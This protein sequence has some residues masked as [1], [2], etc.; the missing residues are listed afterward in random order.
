M[1]A[2]RGPKGTHKIGESAQGLRVRDSASIRAEQQVRALRKETGEFFES[3]ILRTF[4]SKRAAR[5][6]ETRLIERF[7]GIYGDDALPGNLTNR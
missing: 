5:D 6:Y 3:R 2:I 4:D 1:Y 7:R